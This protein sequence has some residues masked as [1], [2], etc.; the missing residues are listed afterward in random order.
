MGL[1]RQQPQRFMGLAVVPMQDPPRAAKVLEDAVV[2]LK[3]SGTLITS[4][5]NG[6]Y[7]SSTDFDPFW[8]KAQELDVLIVMHPNEVAGAERYTQYG[9]LTV[10][11]NPADS[12]LSIGHLVYGGVFD[13]F[14]RLKVCVFHGGGF[15]PYH[16]GRFDRNFVRDAGANVVS[17]SPPSTYLKNLYFDTLVYDPDT[18]DYLRRVAGAEHLLLGTDYPFDLGDWHGVDKVEA[19]D[20]PDGEKEQILHGNARGLLKNLT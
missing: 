20:C 4:N 17:T 19:L 16:L 11:G 6:A 2:N 8:D 9:L 18:L 5:V 12:T 13:R 10:C 15:F 7:Y 1:V 14:P 3:M